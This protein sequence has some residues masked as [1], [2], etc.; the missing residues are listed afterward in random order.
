ME[1]N[2]TFTDLEQ[3]NQS[4]LVN[5][6]IEFTMVQITRTGLEKHILDATGPMRVYFKRKGIHDYE[7]QGKGPEN[8]IFVKAYLLLP[9]VSPVSLETTFY[10]PNTKNG[11]PRLWFKGLAQ[12]TNPFDIYLI[13]A[14]NQSLYLI[15]HTQLNIEEL[16]QSSNNAIKDFIDTIQ[17]HFIDEF[18]PIANELLFKLR[19]KHDQWLVSQS[20]SDTGIG[21]SIEAFLGIPMNSKK[22]PDY[23][24][25][26]LKSYRGNG[27]SGKMTLFGDF[28]DWENL[29]AVKS[30][31]EILNLYGYKYKDTDYLTYNNTLSYRHPNR[32]NLSLNIEKRENTFDLLDMEEGRITYVDETK[33]PEYV[34][35]RDLAKWNLDVVHNALLQKHNRTFWIGVDFQYK[36]KDLLYRLREAEYTKA[37]NI[38]QFDNLLE[39]R[40]ISVELSINRLSIDRKTNEIK[41]YGDNVNFRILKSKRHLLFPTSEIFLL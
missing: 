8:K 39:K 30:I 18:E 22:H 15:N 13:F 11:D 12:Y 33:E 27:K 10:R 2:K 25:I 29:S 6:G 38:A 34:T 40:V 23:K 31:N 3:S 4:F 14:Y 16:Y 36:D 1:R 19:E 9:D 5:K 17:P 21:R 35:V 24:G 20:N 26:E 32:Q 41:R 37:P 28:P 7:I